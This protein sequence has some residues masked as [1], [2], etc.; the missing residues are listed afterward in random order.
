MALIV[1]IDDDPDFREMLQ[2]VLTN[3]GHSV[4]TAVDGN[5]GVR[6]VRQKK[7]D[8]VITDILMPEKEGIE[9]IQELRADNESLPIIAVSGGS[10]HLPSQVGLKVAAHMGAVITLSKP[11]AIADLIDAVDSLLPGNK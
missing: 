4:A 2:D 1:V 8:L 11:V 6:V 10:R 3:E 9:T 7:P 5:D